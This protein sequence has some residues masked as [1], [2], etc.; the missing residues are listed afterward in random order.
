MRGTE[1]QSR[2]ALRYNRFIPARAG[3]SR[4]R[5][6]GAAGVPVYPRP[7]GEQLAPALR[8]STWPRFIPARAGNRYDRLGNSPAIA[9]YPRPCGEQIDDRADHQP[10]DGLSP[11]VR[12]TASRRLHG[13]SKPRFIPARAGNRTSVRHELRSIP[14]YPRPCGEQI[15]ATDDKLTGDGLSPPVRGTEHCEPG[16]PHRGRFIPARAG[17]SVHGR[18]SPQI[19]TV[20]PRPCGEQALR[21]ICS[22][23]SIGLSPPVRGTASHRRRQGHHVRFIPARA[24]NS[25]PFPRAPGPWPVYPRPCGEQMAVDHVPKLRGGLSPPVRGTGPPPG[26]Q[27]RRQRFIPARAGN[28]S[29]PAKWT[30]RAAV[31]PRPCGEQTRD[32]ETTFEAG[33][34]SPPVRGTG[35]LGNRRRRR[36]AV[37]PRPC[38]EQVAARSRC[39]S[40]AGLSP[41]VRGTAKRNAC[42][43]ADV[44]FIPARAGNRAR[45]SR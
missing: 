3:N 23:W 38:G 32:K 19:R 31:Y 30:A 29:S 1:V 7:C 20:Y 12:G 41:P 39:Q 28:S 26:A 16:K 35:E 13:W 36:G 21:A 45:S 8:P 9:V 4:L 34:L 5:I 22:P 37:Y 17:N 18:T 14:V 44:R 43:L 40:A 2:V 11:P 27:R 25:G 10:S 42:H 6:C 24:G 15:D 33:G